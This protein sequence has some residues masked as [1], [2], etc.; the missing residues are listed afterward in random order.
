MGIKK[1]AVIGHPIGHTMSPF[2]HSRLFS[3]NSFPFE[4]GIMDIPSYELNKKI[5]VF[6]KDTPLNGFNITIPHKQAVIPLLDKLDRKAAMCGSVNTVK[7]ENG[8]L[9]GYTTDGEGFRRAVEA[10]GAGLSGRVVIIGAGGA[11]RA[12]AFEAAL[13]GADITIATREHSAEAGNRLCK[14]LNRSVPGARASCCLINDINGKI[15]L[16]VNATPAGMY[17]NTLSCPA[18][19]EILS[20]AKYVFDAVYNPNET[21]MLRTARENGAKA[22]GGMGMLVRQAAAAQEIWLGCSFPESG[23]EQICRETAFAMKKKF[24]NIILCGFMGSGKTTVGKLL[25]KETGRRFADMDGYI[26]KKEGMSVSEI[27]SQRGESYFRTAETE[28]SKALSI[29][30]GLVIAAGGG[31]VLEPQNTD[32]FKSNGIIVM[33]DANLESVKNRLKDDNTRPLLQKSGRETATRNLYNERR[34]VYESAA[35]IKVCADDLPDA[36]V[37]SIRQKLFDGTRI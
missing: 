28:A 27:F 1:Y 33:L 37:L 3:L 5:D 21:L 22:I 30:S 20:N 34:A 31:T 17:P 26:E 15:E 9:T 13:C 24:G 16:L 25:A 10:A 32:A 35:D 18:G 23:I 7:N 29:E 36:V 2:I 4:Y 8:I 12:I 19:A 6:R 11:A 14:D